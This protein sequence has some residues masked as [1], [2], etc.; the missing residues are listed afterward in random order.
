MARWCLPLRICDNLRPH[1]IRITPI[2]PFDMRLWRDA[3]M[4]IDSE[5]QAKSV[6]FQLIGRMVKN[7]H[8]FRY[9]DFPE[10]ARMFGVL[11]VIEKRHSVYSI[12]HSAA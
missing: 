1:R 11:R 6:I 5:L 3:F 4:D 8:L 12:A 9:G 7:A 2:M 10:K